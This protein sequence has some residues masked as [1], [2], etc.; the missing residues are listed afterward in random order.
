MM[1][2]FCGSCRI[3]L[4]Q[5]P[6]LDIL[7]RSVYGQLVIGGAWDMD[8]PKESKEQ[9]LVEAF[10]GQTVLFVLD[11]ICASPFVSIVSNLQTVRSC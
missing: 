8:A 4:G 9:R 3:T 11:D 10:K 5:T 1:G 2:D 6:D 7:Q